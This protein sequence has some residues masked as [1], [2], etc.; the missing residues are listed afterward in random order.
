MAEAIVVNFPKFPKIPK[1]DPIT[2][3]PIPEEEGVVD[4]TN[5]Q[6]VE[7]PDVDIFD[8]PFQGL[9]I[10]G[11]KFE[12]GNKYF[13]AP[14]VAQEIARII[15]VNEKADRRILQSHPDV[16]AINDQ[17]RDGKTSGSV[18]FSKG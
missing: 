13:V 5:W 17:L 11:Y 16:R 4:R 14:E 10:N 15:K 9:S 3:H 1:R 18:E 8:K 12:R 6:Y 2:H 7:I